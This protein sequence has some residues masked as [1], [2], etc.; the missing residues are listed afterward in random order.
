MNIRFSYLYRDAGNFKNWGE[1][2][3]R[4]PLNIPLEDLAKQLRQSLLDEKY[5]DAF[6][7]SVPELFFDDYDEELDHEWHEFECLEQFD[8]APTDRQ[9]RGIDTFI[10]KLTE[11]KLK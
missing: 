8:G 6:S 7:V 5:F 4:N 9:E 2:V 11:K 1:V 3:F 10:S